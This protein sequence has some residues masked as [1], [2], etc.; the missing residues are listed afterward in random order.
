SGIAPARIRPVDHNGPP[1]LAQN[2][3]RVEIAMAQPVA[4]RHVSKTSEQNSLSRFVEDVHPSDVR[5]QPQLQ[6]AELGPWLSV[7]AGLQRTE[8]LEVMRHCGRIFPHLLSK[9][10]MLHAVKHDA[11]RAS[12]RCTPQTAGTGSPIAST[13]AWF[14]ASRNAACLAAGDR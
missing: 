9:R 7:N 11:Q 6:T 14:A 13:A 2:V 5:R 8:C 3:D 1:D 12:I 10:C 4:I